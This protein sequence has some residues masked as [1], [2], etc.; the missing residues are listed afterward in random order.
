MANKK[1]RI[2][3]AAMEAMKKV[4]HP[5]T[6][7][8]IYSVI[9]E[10][11]L[12]TFGADDP[13]GV[14]RGRI[15][16]HC[17]GLDFPSAA[18][19]KYFILLPD[20]KFF[21]KDPPT[22]LTAEPIYSKILSEDATAEKLQHL[23]E[24]YLDNFRE[25]VLEQL[26]QLDPYDFEEFSKQLLEKFG[27]EN[28]VVTSKSDDGGID[29]YGD[30]EMGMGYL[31]FGFQ[32]KRYRDTSIGPN[33]LREFRGAL[34]EQALSQG[35]FF[36]TSTFSKKAQEAALIKAARPVMLFDG[37]QIVDL[38]IEKNFGIEVSMNLL[39]YNYALEL[40][41]MGDS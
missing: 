35:I 1:F 13:I 28:V 30:F 9:L 18:K 38:M 8:E 19:V 41:S 25:R 3:D 5:L 6:I 40:D 22:S 23:Y 11:Q 31:K 32:C 20:G 14:L 34:D 4:G 29:G 7:R 36:T 26:K 24:K 2:V 10:N 39:T 15:R 33:V 27:F 21:L 17:Q 12:F 37:K 16:K